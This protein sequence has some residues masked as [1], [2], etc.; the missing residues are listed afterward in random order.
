MGQS[1][2]FVAWVKVRLNI[3]LSAAVSWI[4]PG[5]FLSL[6]GSKLFCFP[7]MQWGE[8]NHELSFLQ[9]R[10][11]LPQ[12]PGESLWTC[13]RCWLTHRHKP[14]WQRNM[15]HTGFFTEVKRSSRLDDLGRGKCV[16]VSAPHTRRIDLVYSAKI[17]TQCVLLTMLNAVHLEHPKSYQWVT[18][19]LLLPTLLHHSVLPCKHY[20]L[21]E[22][23]SV[24]C[25]CDLVR[26]PLGRCRTDS[27]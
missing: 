1:Q 3:S 9:S 8:L 14:E 10:F 16:T 24:I 4:Q 2:D 6:C 17:F 5:H 23:V 13:G 19:N 15:R 18:K 11:E 7:P 26:L 22:K 27:A 20:F 12:T 25:S 21:F